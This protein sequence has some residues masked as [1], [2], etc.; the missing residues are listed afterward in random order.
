MQVVNAYRQLEKMKQDIRKA[1]QGWDLRR[2]KYEA[3]IQLLKTDIRNLKAGNNQSTI[4][5][6]PQDLTQ[7]LIENIIRNSSCPPNCRTYDESFYDISIL[8]YLQSAK[9][10]K[11]LRQVLPFPSKTCLMG[12]YRDCINDIKLA[13]TS[14]EHSDG[15]VDQLAGINGLATLAIDAFAFRSF[16]GGNPVT[17]TAVGKKNSL[18]PTQTGTPVHEDA[19]KAFIPTHIDKPANEETIMK[20]M[21]SRAK[22]NTNK[23]TFEESTQC[24]IPVNNEDRDPSADI[25]TNG[26]IYLLVPHDSQQPT[27]ILH[28]ETAP[29]GC[30]NEHIDK[31]ANGFMERLKSIGI[32]CICKATDGDRGMTAQHDN[33]YAEFIQGYKGSFHNLLVDVRLKLDGV[34]T[35][36]PVSDPLHFLKCFRGRLIDFPIQVFPNTKP[37]TSWEL[38]E[39]L[40]LGSALTDRTPLS[41]MR[42]S[43]VLQLF[44]F[45]TVLKLLDA[46]KCS[47]AYPFMAFSCIT[48][49]IL[50]VDLEQNLRLFL[51]EIAFHMFNNMLAK[52]PE[53]KL[54][55][56]TEKR[57]KNSVA[58]AVSEAHYIRRIMNTIVALGILVSLEDD[59]V[60][61]DAIGTHLVENAIG[62]ARSTSF[63]PRWC[64]ILVTYACAELR[65]QIAR[66]YGLTLYVHN[67]VNAGGCKLGSSPGNVKKPEEWRLED[68]L[69]MMYGCCFD[70][71]LEAYTPFLCDFIDKLEEL[72]SV[73]R[74]KRVNSSEVA[75]SQILSRLLAFK[76]KSEDLELL[77]EEEVEE[78]PK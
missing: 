32:T 39:V 71:W 73:T 47:A 9:C 55:N 44:N 56:V 17:A 4:Q 76:V 64:R 78:V 46:R 27:K 58:V 72:A 36:I 15:L 24:L 5:Y 23:S 29:N 14:L 57:S 42:D 77:E 21:N 33:F 28:I 37:F 69:T 22:N 38:E 12:K 51:L 59:H 31:I 67:R 1:R 43:F 50:C 63:D 48:S 6:G 8:L 45:Q 40:Q 65:K 66:K 70:E 16:R 53:L 18:D 26:F 35:F 68:I 7:C 62:I 19:R 10:Y 60:R 52:L 11:I 49:A 41:R 61:M 75:N 25:H 2:G 3:Q 54:Q 74:V 30:Y 20:A 13:L 34:Q